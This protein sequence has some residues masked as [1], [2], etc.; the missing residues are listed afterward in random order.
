MD[1]LFAVFAVGVMCLIVIAVFSEPPDIDLDDD[2]YEE[3]V[4]RD[5]FTAS[6]ESHSR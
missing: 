2:D 5:Y 6:K 3:E 4:M 1:A